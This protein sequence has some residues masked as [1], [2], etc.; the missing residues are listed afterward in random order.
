MSNI[1]VYPFRFSENF[2]FRESHGVRLDL[3]LPTKQKKHETM[4]CSYAYK[5][6]A[7]MC[8]DYTRHSNFVHYGVFISKIVPGF[9]QFRYLIAYTTSSV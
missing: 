2:T 5:F 6:Y 3:L 9:V 1:W 4:V 7:C 8:D